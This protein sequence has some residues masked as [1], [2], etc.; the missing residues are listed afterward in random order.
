MLKKIQSRIDN[1]EI[2]FNLEENKNYGMMMS[3]GIDSAILLYLILKTYQERGWEPRIQPF[4]MRKNNESSASATRMLEYISTQFPGYYIPPT[5]EVGDPNTHHRLQGVAAWKE[6]KERFPEVDFV[7]YGS[8][9]VPP[10]DYS[11]WE[12]DEFGLPRG[13]PQRSSGEGG[14]V[15]LP[16][17]NIYK[18]HTVDLV[19]E[20]GQEK[21]FEIARSCTQRL[22]GPR[23][24]ICFQCREREWGFSYFKKVDPGIG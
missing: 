2:T 5:T 7:F 16:F 17:L 20:N 3:G 19:Y 12:K 13:R 9:K 10:W 4:T 8:N 15:Y 23:C 21:M 24:G 11:N 22:T 18:Y 6:I 1:T 14:I